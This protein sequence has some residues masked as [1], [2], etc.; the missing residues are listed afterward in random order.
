MDLAKQSRN[1]DDS[2]N[3]VRVSHEAGASL[4]LD[5]AINTYGYV[6]G[7]SISKTDSLGLQVALPVIP[8]PVGIPGSGTPATPGVDPYNQPLPGTRYFWPKSIRDAAQSIYDFCLG[9]ETPSEEFFRKRRN[10]CITFYQYELDMP[11]RRDNFGPHRACV[12][13]CMNAVGCDLWKLAREK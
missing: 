4:G 12:R 2:G 1:D 7:N 6:E 11:G 5:V 10:Y 9:K 13:R 3:Q 8:P